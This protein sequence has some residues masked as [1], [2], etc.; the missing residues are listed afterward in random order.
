MSGILVV[1]LLVVA[2]LVVWVAVQSLGTQKKGQAIE[3]QMNEL[4]RD[5]QSVAQAQ[6]QAAGQISTLASNVTQRL[7][8]VAKS[9]TDGVASSHIIT[10]TTSST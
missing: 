3:T 8:T 7:D 10:R 1:G 4:R 9:L 5:L 6:A 2:V